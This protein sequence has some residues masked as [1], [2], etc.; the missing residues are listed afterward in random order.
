MLNKYKIIN[1]PLYGFITI[2]SETIFDI[3]SH[4]Y[5]QRLR[6]IKQL[7]LA[8][9]VYPGAN[10]TR[11]HHALGAMHLMELTLNSLRQ[12]GYEI[13]ESEYEASLI[14]ILLHDI[15]HGP[16]SHVLE[17][18]IL[19]DIPHEEIT[20]LF[21]KELNQAFEGKLN[22]AIDIFIGIYERQLFHQLV[23]SQLDMDRL[24]YLNRD[25]Y[26]TGVTEGKVSAERI[27]QMFEI[28]DDEIVIAEKGIYSVEHFLNAR[29]LMYWQVYLHKTTIC[30]EEMLIQII[31]RLKFLIQND[32]KVEVSNALNLLL[33]QK[34]NLS[35]FEKDKKLIENFGSLDDY[36][37][38]GGIKNW[39]NHSDTVLSLLCQMLLNRNL[40]KIKLYKEPI[41]NLFLEE[42]DAKICKKYDI[43]IENLPYLRINGT[44]SNASYISK[45]Q[46]IKIL[47][48]NKHVVDITEASDLPNI[49]AMNEIVK[50]YYLCTATI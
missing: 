22:L 44:F 15:G 21:M 49:I 46:R 18:T 38:W 20:Y 11:F 17:N 10:H 42:L 9:F 14:A 32:V 47:K 43:S 28:V 3:I 5:F 2:Y 16:F 33:K 37:V 4:P 13:S 41:G 36:D 30:A 12:K 7:G 24:D 8:D 25:A 35:D 29:R 23:S 31:K 48:K 50:K 27:I 34:Y 39:S 40:F 1:D 45:G 26:F 19:D 6:R